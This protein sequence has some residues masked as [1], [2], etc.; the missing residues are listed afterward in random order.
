MGQPAAPA[1]TPFWGWSGWGA[2]GALAATAGV[3][4]ASIAIVLT[5]VSILSTNRQ[6]RETRTR[7][8]LNS[9][10]QTRPYIGLDVVPSVW[11]SPAFDLIIVNRGRS[12]ARKVRLSLVNAAFGPRTENDQLGA[13][14]AK[15]FSND[16]ELAPEARRRFIWHLGDT[17]NS[18]PPGE[19][20]A[21]P[22]GELRLT[23]EWDPGDGRA[24]IQY[25]D[26]TRYE[27]IE[28]PN[29]V[30]TPNSGA[31]ATSG[32]DKE[33]RNVG[34]ALRAIAEHLGGMR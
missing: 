26:R 8:A 17:P 30:P 31:T 4:V 34:L 13:R 33:L 5:V 28:T 22:T 12:T 11:G 23:Y 20:G 14:Q 15:V 27:L 7:E 19:Q 9:D 2:V 3:L 21:P 6:T 1:T 25:E 10:A 29:L 18:E 16:F 24:V 32:E